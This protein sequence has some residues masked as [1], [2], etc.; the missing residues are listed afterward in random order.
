MIA[1]RALA[2]V[3]ASFLGAVACSVLVPNELDR[4]K[5]AD[6]G[7][8]GPPACPA[9]QLCSGGVCSPCSGEGCI[10]DGGIT[11]VGALCDDTRPCDDALFCV[12][13]TELGF[14]GPRYCSKGC[15]S[16]ES[17]GSP[18]SICIPV[19]GGANMCVPAVALGR[20]AGQKVRGSSCNTPSDCRSGLCEGGTCADVCCRNSECG[21][22][23]ACVLRDIPGIGGRRGFMCGA[24]GIA[25]SGACTGGGAECINR[26]C[27]TG[28]PNY[29]SG[30]CCKKSDCPAPLSCVY[31]Q[32]E[33][34]R[35]C[36]DIPIATGTSAVGAPCADDEDCQS[37]LCQAFVPI[38]KFCTDACCEDKDCGN[39]DL[40]ACRPVNSQGSAVLL[41]VPR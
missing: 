35:A 19:Q 23:E 3:V 38:G 4:V 6:E 15:C 18:F 30:P 26:L 31:D 41:C 28:A 8:L 37:S 22:G 25:V 27:L 21:S 9:G 36:K 34:L 32:A 40:V 16:S 24:P 10:S 33:G 39:P 5:C 17:C 20:T 11:G 2:L 13:P 14:N 29:C 12:S 7:A 1:R